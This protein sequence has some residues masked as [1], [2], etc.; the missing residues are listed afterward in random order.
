MSDPTTS[1]L[2]YQLIQPAD[3]VSVW[4]SVQNQNA[5]IADASVTVSQG[6]LAGRPSAGTYGRIYVAT[7]D[8]TGGANGTWY[9][10][11]GTSWETVNKGARAATNIAASQSTSASTYTTLS[12]PDQVS[13]YLPTNGL[14]Q[15]YYHATWQES[16]LNAGRIGMF[17][18]NTQVVAPI[19]GFSTPQPVELSYL[20]GAG[21]GVAFTVT[22]TSWGLGMTSNTSSY[23]GDVTTGQLVAAMPATTD[24]FVNSRDGGGAATIFAAAGTYAVAIK[25]KASSGSVTASNR[26]LWVEAKA[27]A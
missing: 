16:V 10:D 7:D 19:P 5:S 27:F 14:I 4:P 9:W 20:G 23:T 25:F 2:S 3:A 17:L 22:T 6:L 24:T 11:N 12:T 18:G 8:L 21:P 15:V 26:R 1:R 13:V